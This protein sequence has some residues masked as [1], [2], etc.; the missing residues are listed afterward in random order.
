MPDHTSKI[1]LIEDNPA[2]VRFLREVFQE[3][4]ESHFELDHCGTLSEAT[5][6]LENGKPDIALVDLGLPDSMG[7]EAIRR[8]S[9]AA[10]DIPMVVLTALN[11]ESAAMKS[12]E[13]GA[14]DYLVKGSI[15]AATLSRALRYAMQRHRMQSD[16]RNIALRDDLTGL[17][18]RRG[19]IGLAEHHAQLAYRTKR[20]F[21]LAFVDLDG[22]KQIN[23]TFGHQEGNR[24]LV[25]AADL[26]RDSF[27]YSDILGRLGG[28]EFAAIVIEAGKGTMETVTRRLQQK[29]ATYNSRPGCRYKLS[30]SVGIVAWNGVDERPD[31]GRLMSQADEAM[32]TQ[33]KAKGASRKT[34]RQML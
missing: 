7:L 18:N 11:D 9:A 8:I 15:D 19:F 6:Y 33:K 21:L 10:P 17:N 13:E 23:D 22:M 32:Y 16:L 25:D 3:M 24:A 34:E 2:D 30:F 5:K 27:R 4:T 14:Q 28:D 12:L 20:S 31:I 26:L 29:L 1:L